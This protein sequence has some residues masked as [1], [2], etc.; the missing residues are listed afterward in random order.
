MVNQHSNHSECKAKIRSVQDTLDILG[1]KWK[2]SIIGCLSF[3]KKRFMELQREV[4]GIGAKMLSKE[5]R[6]LEINELVNRTVYN[7]KPVTVEYE[8]TDYGKTLQDIIMAMTKWGEN[9]RKRIIRKTT[10]LSLT[11]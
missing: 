10:E 2:I 11:E 3:G 4:E 5:L 9:H 1:G 6:D 7:T 8:L